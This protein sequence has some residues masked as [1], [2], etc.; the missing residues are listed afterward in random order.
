MSWW[1]LNDR[2]RVNEHERIDSEEFGVKNLKF[3][4][5]NIERLNFKNRRVEGLKL[6]HQIED[7][8]NVQH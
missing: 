6:E 8:N 7:T 5:H 1:I 4:Q 3:D 2:V